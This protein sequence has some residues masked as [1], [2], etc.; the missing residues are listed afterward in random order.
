MDRSDLG[1]FG[2]SLPDGELAQALAA[3]SMLAQQ[4]SLFWTPVIVDDVVERLAQGA[5]NG[6]CEVAS[7]WLEGGVPGHYAAAS[8]LAEGWRHFLT[9]QP[10]PRLEVQS[11]DRDTA[12]ETASWLA[13]MCRHRDVGAAS[14]YLRADEPAWPVA[15]EWPL[16][17][18]LL[19]LSRTSSRG[20]RLAR[21]LTSV[22]FQRLWSVV[23]M[24]QPGAECELLLLP[25]DLRR[26]LGDVLDA[27][28]RPRAD[29]VLVLGGTRMSDARSLTLKAALRREA[30]TAG[31]AVLNAGAD[32]V[33]VLTELMR[34]LSHDATLDVALFR[35]SGSAVARPRFA[36]SA[37]ELL[38]SRTLATRTSVRLS[39]ARVLRQ[40]GA[41]RKKLELG[42]D[43][44]AGVGADAAAGNIS[45]TAAITVVERFGQPAADEL[46]TLQKRVEEGLWQFESGD[47]TDFVNIREAIAGST[48]HKHRT[49]RMRDLP[50]VANV[51]PP[52]PVDEQDRREV[53]AQLHDESSADLVTVLRPDSSY[54]LKVKIALPQADFTS[55]GEAFSSHL[56]PPSPI[57]HQLDISFI[58]LTARMNG[59]HATPQQRHVFLPADGE[60]TVAEFAFNTHGMQREFR[61]R[62]LVSHENRVIQTLRLDGDINESR[63]GQP[64]SLSVENVVQPGFHNL[65]YQAPFDAALVVN[66]S[67]GGQPGLT[68]LS[69]S[70]IS[71]LEP[72][73]MG[74]MLEMLKATLTD[75]TALRKA[76][77]SLDS[78]SMTDLV[79]ALTQ[80]GRLLYDFVEAQLGSLDEGASR[81]QVIEA[82]P[83]AYFPAEFLYPLEVP[84][85]KPP[86]CPQAKAALTGSASSHQSCAHRDDP[87]FLCPLRFWGF[88]KQI[89]RQPPGVPA[90]GPLGAMPV[91]PTMTAGKLD[92]F[93]SAQV[94]R[95]SRVESADYDLPAGLLKVLNK[96][97]QSVETSVSWK[98]WKGAVAERSPGFLLLLSHSTEDQK[99]H[100][101]ALEISKDVL[102]VAS[103]EATYVKSPTAP[104]PVV[105]LMG[106]STADPKVGFL[107]FVERFKRKQAALV[108][109]TLS[110]ISAQRAAR[111]LAVALP[112]FK[113]AENSGRTFGE[114]FLEVKRA[115]LANGDGFALSLVAYGDMSWQI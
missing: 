56:L 64:Y 15:W 66:H 71:F 88:R 100:L 108:V 94:A 17:L 27:P 50:D 37:P 21:E 68:L 84:P 74:E 105:F 107:N 13:R 112:I 69:D 79:Y 44:V 76:D 115:A 53:L 41:D 22:H 57:G 39:A 77:S 46:W 78:E 87:E 19:G 25:G 2:I 65:A 12:T 6:L 36:E 81:I 96:N 75:E 9:R 35:A 99:S 55:A 23:D 70:T 18:G 104:A 101:P 40:F 49:A 97:F 72:A 5:R 26:A 73:G 38:F 30:R 3:L 11:R 110:T 52:R 90:G 93:H 32:P 34:E 114:V 16:R 28:H 80:H 86:L 33:R 20:A 4:G 10:Q 89:E 8:Q 47:A 91:V 106:C 62:I 42:V 102:S 92:L 51:V 67:V 113:T 58:P 43:G 103:L 109:G 31:I 60:S 83:G 61:S 1:R 82:R 7:W 29:C 24:E 45:E 59:E 95:S 48:G 111:F 85:S 98:Q 63:L 54:A 14:V